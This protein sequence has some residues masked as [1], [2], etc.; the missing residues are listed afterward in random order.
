MSSL[1]SS[2]CARRMYLNHVHFGSL[3]PVDTTSVSVELIV[4]I[5]NFFAMFNIAPFPM[6][7]NKPECPHGF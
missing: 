6:V 1:I 3:S 7:A 2:P 4:T 5:P